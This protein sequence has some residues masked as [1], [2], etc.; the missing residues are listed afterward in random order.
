MSAFSYTAKRKLISGHTEDTAYDIDIVCEQITA[1]VKTDKTVHTPW[2]GPPETIFRRA[3]EYRNIATG[4]VPA[5][6]E[7]DQILEFL[8]SVYAGE[9]FTFDEH[10]AAASPDNPVSAMLDGDFSEV[11]TSSRGLYKYSFKILLV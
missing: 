5:G 11:V 3:D 6:A 8:Y 2:Q 7:R 4:I 10:G 1:Q 9:I